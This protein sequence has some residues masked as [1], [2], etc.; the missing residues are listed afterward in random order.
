MDPVLV[1]YPV[2]VADKDR[3]VSQAPRAGVE[4]GTWFECPLHPIETP[5]HLYDYAEGSCPVAEQAAREVVNL[6][7]HPRTD[8]HAAGR[9]FEYVKGMLVGP[10]NRASDGNG[11]DRREGAA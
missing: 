7:T 5:L 10:R 3:A 9:T 1:R 2:R 11:K 6:P 4:I 8:L